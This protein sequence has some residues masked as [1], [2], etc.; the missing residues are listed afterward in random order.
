MVTIDAARAL[1][2]EDEI[3]SLEP[4]KKADIILIDLRQPHLI[5]NFMVAHRVVYEAIGSDV[6]TVIVDGRI[7]MQKRQV[8]TVSEDEILEAA[9]NEAVATVDRAGLHSY[10]GMPSTFWGHAYLRP[11]SEQKTAT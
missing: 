6:D 1:G 7:I 8:L 3:G 11:G 5:P 4:G 9:Q 2:W 10:M